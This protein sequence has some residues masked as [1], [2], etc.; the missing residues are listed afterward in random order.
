M[1]FNSHL[2]RRARR[3]SHFSGHL[4]RSL[5]PIC[6][7]TFVLIAQARAD[8]PGQTL[9]NGIQLPAQWPPKP[10]AISYEP[11]ELP[12]LQSP[13]KVIPIDVGRQL[14]IDDFLIE[15]T[16]LVRKFYT[17]TYVPEDPVMRPDKPWEQTGKNP[18]A[19]VFSDGVWFDPKDHLFKMWYMGGELQSTCYAMSKDGIHWEKPILDVVPGTNIVRKALRD[20]S[21][22]WLD[23]NE[24][25]P[26]RRFKM[27]SIWRNAKTKSWTIELLFSPDGIH[28][29]D[30]LYRTEST[31]DRTTVFY[32]PFRNVWVFGL[33]SD[34]P[35]GRARKYWE[36]T[37]ALETAKYKKT[38][39][40]WWIGAD[41]HDRIRDDL[42]TR[43]QLYNLDAAAY[44]SVMLG[45]FTIWRGQPNDRA[46]P[47]EVMIGW[48]RDGWHWDRSNRTP[49]LPVSEHHGDWNWCNVQSC[50]GGC[51]IVGDQLYFYCSGRAGIPGSKS[52][53]VSTT[54]L[55][56]MRRDGFAAMESPL[57]PSG[58]PMPGE[59]TTRPLRFT[60]KHLF[61]NLNTK[62]GG[63][64]AEVL[65]EKG[66]VIP[67]FTA[68]DCISITGDRTALPIQWKENADLSKLS[69][70]TVRFRFIMN[71]M[72]GT[73][74]LYAFWV[75]PEANG[76]SHGYVAAGGPGFEGPM[77]TVGNQPAAN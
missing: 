19:M 64:A 11:M 38:D 62:D 37:D 30:V 17:P 40:S 2:S 41:S 29:G 69:G 24:N 27:F 74:H 48:S 71:A 9:Y 21:T 22:V 55:A 16:T 13:P 23:Q 26:S 42:K 34:S 53:G 77:D 68:A 7:L 35:F 46:K 12:Y 1:E 49:F 61:V 20:S 60:G 47:N 44:E 76:A 52:S 72:K 25:D 73:G 75:S 8:E 18:M 32:N 70:K 65:D 58:A 14:F 33:R 31:G 10:S 36:G 15:K 4:F 57:A 28:W 3:G 6:V 45:F 43:A 50:G 51:L 5:Q 66:D 56:T 54:S 67:G 59:L 63:F 39:P